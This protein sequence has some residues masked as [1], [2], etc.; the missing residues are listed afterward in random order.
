MLKQS[1]MK[2]NPYLRNRAVYKRMLLVNVS[3][4]TTIELGS[5]PAWLVKALKK[6]PASNGSKESA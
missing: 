5:K 2:T 3:S 1:L 6:G 4:S